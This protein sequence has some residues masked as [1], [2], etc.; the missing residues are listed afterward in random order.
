MSTTNA[1]SLLR[2]SAFAFAG[3]NRYRHSPSSIAALRGACP[4]SVS[5]TRCLLPAASCQLLPGCR[6]SPRGG[7]LEQWTP[8]LA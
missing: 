2:E 3:M 1:D 6:L 8:V 4:V 7:S 5:P